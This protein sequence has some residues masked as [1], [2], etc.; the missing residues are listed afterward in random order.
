MVGIFLECWHHYNQNLLITSL[1]P[2]QTLGAAPPL[3]QFVVKIIIRFLH[4]SVYAILDYG[5]FL[6]MQFIL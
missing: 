6:F 3:V 5:L 4:D 1:A 2:T